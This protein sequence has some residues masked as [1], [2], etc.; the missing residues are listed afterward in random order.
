MVLPAA[1]LW[2]G[3]VEVREGDRIGTLGFEIA[4]APARSM[5]AQ[6]WAALAF[7]ALALALFALH[8]WLR[9]G[10]KRRLEPLRVRAGYTDG[11]NRVRS[12]RP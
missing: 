11:G 12:E 5:L 6:H 3:S 1:G 7:P 2:R 10:R 9:L 8:Q 4:V